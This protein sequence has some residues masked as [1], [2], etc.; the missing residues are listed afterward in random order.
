[1]GR[2]SGAS[3]ALVR[4]GRAGGHPRKFPPFRHQ[5]CGEEDAEP[6][7]DP[8]REPVEAGVDGRLRGHDGQRVMSVEFWRLGLRSAAGMRRAATAANVCLDAVQKRFQ[9]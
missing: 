5:R 9:D 1:M 8:P 4:H 6:L 7:F 3:R 2:F